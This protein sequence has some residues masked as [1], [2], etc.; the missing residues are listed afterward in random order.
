VHSLRAPAHRDATSSG[1]W[2]GPAPWDGRRGLGR[3]A[4]ALP[5]LLLCLSSRAEA[6][7]TIGPSYQLTV[8]NTKQGNE[9]VLQSPGITYAGT[10]GDAWAF[11]PTFTLFFPVSAYQNQMHF[12]VSSTYGSAWGVDVVFAAARRICFR[13]G[14]QLDVGV[15]PHFN[16]VVMKGLRIGHSGFSDFNSFT[17]GVGLNAV[18]RWRVGSGPF[19]VG[20]F[21]SGAVDFVDLLHGGDLSTGFGVTTGALVGVEL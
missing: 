10:M 6:Q 2:V 4:S 8:I 15:G 20:A 16:G 11:Q 1:A 3:A 21:G 12:D 7:Q 5:L 18:L 9:S 19:S 17:L 13:S 14:I